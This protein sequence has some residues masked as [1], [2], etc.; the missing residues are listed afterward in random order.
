MTQADPFACMFM[1]YN[2]VLCC[3]VVLTDTNVL[4]MIIS[5]TKEYRKPGICFSQLSC[6]SNHKP[7]L[8]VLLCA[9][10]HLTCNLF[11]LCHPLLV[12]RPWIIPACEPVPSCY[13]CD[14]VEQANE[15]SHR[16]PTERWHSAPSDPWRKLTMQLQN[17]YGCYPH[18]RHITIHQIC[19]V[20]L[21]PTQNW[22][23]TADS[24][25]YGYCGGLLL[26]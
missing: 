12:K 6:L 23:G 14:S 16:T 2:F 26:G 3:S 7:L 10:N 9:S 21:G 25:R 4:A 20:S 15:S 17:R 13:V 24:R 22:R 11:A 8:Q 5:I 1:S 18:S 19:F